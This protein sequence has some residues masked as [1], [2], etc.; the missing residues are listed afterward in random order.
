[1]TTEDT[2][3]IEATAAEVDS[4]P[5]PDHHS[6]PRVVRYVVDLLRRY[7]ATT[8]LVLT[9]LVVGLATGA[10]WN[11]VTEDTDIFDA[12]AYGLP[13]LQ[14]GKWWTFL[15]GMFFAPR[16]ILYLPIV[17]VL[18]LVASVYE[19]RVGHVRVLVVAIGGQFFGALLT[20]LFLWI[21]E[22]SGWT[23]AENLA[24][25][26][27]L[28]ISAGGFALLG[29]LT[30]AMQPV[31]RSG[32]AS[33]SAPTCSRWSSTPGCCGTS[34]TSSPSRSASSPA[35]SS[36]AGCRSSRGCTSAG[37]ASAPASP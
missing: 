3:T 32:S 30:A 25:V 4:A 1:M 29:A 20:A 18:V 19:R 36:S 15:T 14:D 35:R 23:W 12:V 2:V 26:R 31:W 24:T 33:A 37:A 28:G 22:D 5:A 34:S 16:L 27:D 10:F 7:W 8:A 21:F 9:I 11:Q 17:V 6:G 13:A